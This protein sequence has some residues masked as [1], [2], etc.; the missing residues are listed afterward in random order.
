MQNVIDVDCYGSDG[1]T[2]L[3]QLTQWDMGQVVSIDSI[4]KFSDDPPEIHWCNRMSEECLKV[5]STFKNDKLY[6]DVPN[7]LLQEPYPIIGYVYLQ[8]SNTVGTTIIR[9]RIPVKSRQKPSDYNYIENVDRITLSKINNKLDN[10]CYNMN[11]IEKILKN[12]QTKLVAGTLTDSASVEEINNMI[13]QYFDN[14][15]VVDVESK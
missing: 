6:M 10:V 12:I 14:K 5:K 3:K 15:K 13:I 4:Y 9:F 1:V 8:E 2:R 7:I 11:E